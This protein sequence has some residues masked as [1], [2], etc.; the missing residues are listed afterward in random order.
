METDNGEMIIMENVP[1]LSL[2]L[3]SGDK[4]DVT[5]PDEDYFLQIKA[6]GFAEHPLAV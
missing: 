2:T 6:E 3:V 4:I 1:S 5:F